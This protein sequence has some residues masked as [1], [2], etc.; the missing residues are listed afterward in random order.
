MRLLKFRGR[1]LPSSI[2]YLD[3]E[4]SKIVNLGTFRCRPSV[5]LT[6]NRKPHYYNYRQGSTCVASGVDQVVS[7]ELDGAGDK[8]AYV[9]GASNYGLKYTLYRHFSHYNTWPRHSLLQ[10]SNN[11]LITTF[12]QRNYSSNSNENGRMR[13][14][15]VFVAVPNPIRAIRN[16]VYSWLIRGYFDKE[17]SMAEFTEGAK[18][19]M[20]VVSQKIAEGNFEGLVGLVS[21]KTIAEVEDTYKTL[22]VKDRG[23]LG[24]ELEDILHV[25]PYN[26]AVHYD[27]AGGK[28]LN[29]LM[30]YWCLSFNADSQ[31]DPGIVG[32]KVG[33][34]PPG[35][36]DEQFK[37]MGKVY[38]C[39][40]EFH[41]DV[42]S[43]E[44]TNWTITQ[45]TLG[46]LLSTSSDG[47]HGEELED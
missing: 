31:N 17:F 27:K 28:F 10:S 11:L 14:K 23:S 12:S 29:I 32:F 22:G 8:N 25:V 34:P 3:Y 37:N 20:S 33:Q 4:L 38:T 40:F 35:M 21:P 1:I 24:I 45:V 7:R 39:T 42:S 2:H 9:A 44:D 18:Q 36:S 26:V 30:R 16:F 19:A 47:F 13:V 41:R 5:N 15:P 43:E 6:L 46:K